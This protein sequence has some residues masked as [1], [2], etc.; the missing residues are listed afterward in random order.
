VYTGRASCYFTGKVSIDK[1]RYWVP[2]QTKFGKCPDASN[3]STG[4][5]GTPYIVAFRSTVSTAMG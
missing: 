5:K 4:S 1:V 2:S 3:D